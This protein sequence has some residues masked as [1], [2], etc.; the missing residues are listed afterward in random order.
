MLLFG[1]AVL[2]VGSAQPA[3][4]G[5]NFD[6]WPAYLHD[7]TH[8][9]KNG[10]D[11]D[12]A[13][14]Q[15]STLHQAWTFK[16]DPPTM[17]GQ[18]GRGILS[19]PVIVNGIVYIGARSG[20]V[21]ALSETTGAVL[22]SVFTGF[23]PRLTCPANGLSSSPTVA[24]DPVTRHM[25][26]YLAPPDGN[27]WA[28]DAI[29]GVVRWKVVVNTPSTTVNDYYAWG[30]PTL[31]AGRIFVGGSSS[32][33]HPLVRGSV[34]SFDQTTGARLA[35]Y[36][37]V[38]D[39]AVGGGVW[40]TPAAT[41]AS[42]WVT[43]GNADEQG[44]QPGD[45]NSIV[46]LDAA[47]LT[48]DDIWTVPGISKL[49]LD[50]GASPTLFLAR[51]KGVWTQ[52]VGA[53][54]KDGVFYAWQADDLAAG[55]VWTYQVG[56][57]PIATKE[58]S[59]LA[60]A[61][62]DASGRN[63]YHASN[64]TKIGS[65]AYLAAVRHLDPATGTPLWQTGLPSGPVLSTPTLNGAGVLAVVT[66]NIINPTS[67]A[68]YLIDAEDGSILRSITLNA[69]AFAQPAFADNYLFVATTRGLT[70]WTP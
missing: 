58:R 19:S 50:F 62:W 23:Q 52:M 59:C 45:S 6:N 5:R 22:W 55:P 43:T 27:L 16:P 20:V 69:G 48:V 15:V 26:L 32:C 60:A 40:S 24:R 2:L 3:A 42:I 61:V 36:Y 53:C 67:N 31:A 25:T 1:A 17:P 70:V 39:G 13:A 38:P 51:L 7:A 18:P 56:N 9:S 57:P 63:L 41:G 35:T 29:T 33:D 37:V 68:L 10:S 21:Y 44:T 12:I 49:D 8:T 34:Q 66:F 28:I 54:N 4:S 65:T 47:T 30:S 46:R 14:S 11:S 64:N